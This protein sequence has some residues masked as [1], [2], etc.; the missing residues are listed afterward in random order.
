MHEGI[1]LTEVGE[2]VVNPQTVDVNDAED[3]ERKTQDWFAVVLKKSG[4]LEVVKEK[5]KSGILIRIH[6]DDIA[7]VLQIIKGREYSI[8]RRTV[9][10]VKELAEA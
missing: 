9:F 5:Y 1:G 6:Q 8:N 3:K 4:H 7:E 10:E 2:N